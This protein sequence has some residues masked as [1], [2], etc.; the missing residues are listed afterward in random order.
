MIVPEN[1]D[2]SDDEVGW[3]AIPNWMLRDP[4]IDRNVK[5]VYI[6]MSG[7]VN[8]YKVCWPSQ[9]SIA[10]DAGI[11]VAT[12]KRAIA[13]MV[14]LGILTVSVQ[15]HATGRRNVYRLHIHPFY[16]DDR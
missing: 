15:K 12:V 2:G 8:R 16:G 9:Q 14:A 6:V 3:S 1:T 11:S 10:D 4:S 7:R 5:M 13:Q